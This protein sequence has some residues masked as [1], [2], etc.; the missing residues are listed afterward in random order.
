MRRL[1]VALVALVMIVPALMP[2]GAS[3]FDYY[4]RVWV[5]GTCD[6]WLGASRVY[7]NLSFDYELSCQH[8]TSTGSIKACLQ[9]GYS[10]GTFKDW[11]C[12]T[13]KMSGTTNVFGEVVCAHNHS[14]YPKTSPWRVYLYSSVEGVERFW[15]QWFYLYQDKFPGKP[16]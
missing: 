4:A 9:R 15:S 6:N 14:I 2:S 11:V 12:Q 1:V 3:A 7:S 16:C 5:G 13:T 10:D 8:A